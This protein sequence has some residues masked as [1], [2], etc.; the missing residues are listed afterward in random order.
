MDYFFLSLYKSLLICWKYTTK[1]ETCFPTTVFMVY[2]LILKYSCPL[3]F[4]IHLFTKVNAKL[5]EILLSIYF[6]ILPWCLYGFRLSVNHHIYVTLRYHGPIHVH[7]KRITW[8]SAH[9]LQKNVHVHVHISIKCKTK[10]MLNWKMQNIGRFPFIG[11][12]LL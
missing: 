5:Y 1:F 9:S 4:K 3:S 10:F 11:R 12:S 7:H 2:N 6:Y 8:K